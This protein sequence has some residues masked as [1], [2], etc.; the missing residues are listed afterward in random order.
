M[1]I[2]VKFGEWMAKGWE[3][4]KSAALPLILGVL[5]AML[6]SAV[7][8]GILSAPMWAGMIIMALHLVD[9]KN[10][11]EVEVGMIFQG[12]K[13]FLPTFLFSLVWG[14]I[15]MVSYVL[16][17]IPC[18]GYLVIMAAFIGLGCLLMFGFYLIVDRKMAF[19]PASMASMAMV[20]E[21]F[22][23]LLGYNLVAGLIGGS[24]AMVCGIGQIATWPLA[25]CMLAVAYRECFPADGSD[26]KP[27]IE[28]KP[29]ASPVAPAETKPTA[30][31]EPV[32]ANPV[33]E[34]PIEDKK[35]A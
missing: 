19:W 18:L 9:G 5:V 21:N 11:D 33:E 35:D 15:M 7:S 2:E 22:W 25:L 26:P 1:K 32:A 6:L 10:K 8:M 34:K 23:P 17:V 29:V 30:P 4:Y 24:G 16:I 20:K 14:L 12:F 13:H 28:E 31:S 27:V 3:L